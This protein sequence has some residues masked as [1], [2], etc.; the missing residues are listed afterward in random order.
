MENVLFI[1]IRLHQGNLMFKLVIW[2]TDA[3]S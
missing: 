2:K 3:F 1:T